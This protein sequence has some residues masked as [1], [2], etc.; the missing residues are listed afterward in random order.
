MNN[1][2][3]KM[4][5]LYADLAEFYAFDKQKYTLEE[6]FTDLKKFKDDFVEA[7][8]DNVRERELEEKKEKARQAKLKQEKDREEREANKKRLI[9]M[10][11]SQTQEGVMDSLLEAL[12]TG[13]AFGREQ[14][15]RRGRPAGGNF[16]LL[17]S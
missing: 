14:K 12:S 2:F 13:S 11:P 9:D 8:K 15:R 3:K 10:N 1:M 4:E 17:Q 5:T 7:H 6:F 16:I